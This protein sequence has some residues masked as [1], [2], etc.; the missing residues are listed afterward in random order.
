MIKY[1]N[2]KTV[3]LVL[4]VSLA[5]CKSERPQMPGIEIPDKASAPVTINNN[6]QLLGSWK[7]SKIEEIFI[8][9]SD[10]TGIEKRDL[11]EEIKK[12][13][14]SEASIYSFFKDGAASIIK[15]K[16]FLGAEWSLDGDSAEINK[17]EKGITDPTGIDKF[18]EIKVF[19]KGGSPY[20][21]AKVEGLGI[22][23]FKQLTAAIKNAN[24]EPFHPVNNQ[25]RVAAKKSE[26]YK[27]MRQRLYN[28]TRHSH[29]LFK[30][31]L[32]RQETKIH[33]SSTPSIYKYYD[34]A[35]ALVDGGKVPSAWMANFHS[36]EEAM[37]AYAMAKKYFKRNIFR[38]SE[39]E[40]KSGYVYANEAVFR[41][42]LEK[43][44]ADL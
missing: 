3:L 13:I 24:E 20:F 26:T 23:Q 43:M 18:K 11:R 39:K 9:D 44:E 4:I 16:K 5:S 21:Q 37:D 42:L 25:W 29:Y 14:K 34:G 30:S 17:L 27:Q 7:I 32:E 8:D 6:S 33:A 38:G 22:F 15:D 31:A 19:N 10:L 28:Y 36:A 35:I 12:E 2:L 41:E 40:A 1:L